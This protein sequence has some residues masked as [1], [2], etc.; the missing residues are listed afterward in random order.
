MKRHLLIYTVAGLFLASC[1]ST[2]DRTATAF[3]G[4]WGMSE[5][6]ES[7]QSKTEKSA[8]TTA[9]KKQQPEEIQSAIVVEAIGQ[10]QA[11][12]NQLGEK[13]SLASLKKTVKESVEYKELNAVEKIIINKALNKAEKEISKKPVTHTKSTEKK[14]VNSGGLSQNEMIIAALLCLFLGGL[15]AHRFYLGYTT[16]GIIQLLTGGGCG[17]WVLIDLIRILTGDLGRNPNKPL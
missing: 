11:G 16:I 17:I 4:G 15:G 1:S 13:A 2:V 3:G 12:Q 7:Y 8:E 9:Q 5:K 6:K 14:A 10:N